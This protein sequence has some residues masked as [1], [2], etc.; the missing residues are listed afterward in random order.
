MNNAVNRLLTLDASVFCNAPAELNAVIVNHAKLGLVPTA[1]LLNKALQ[2]GGT[3]H[4]VHT[5]LVN[6]FLPKTVQSI[7]LLPNSL[8]VQT[9]HV[10]ATSG[11]AEARSVLSALQDKWFDNWRASAVSKSTKRLS[12]KDEP[13]VGLYMD[14]SVE[15]TPRSPIMDSLD[16]PAVQSGLEGI[17]QLFMKNDP[18]TLVDV[19]VIVQA[20]IKE[21]NRRDDQSLKNFLHQSYLQTLV[22]IK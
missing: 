18:K 10:L 2:C 9:F 3:P 19:R 15:S 22:G 20:F 11:K 4:P 21:A 14:R 7:H 1:R 6:T 16:N 13:V 12:F 5:K 17:E 8:A